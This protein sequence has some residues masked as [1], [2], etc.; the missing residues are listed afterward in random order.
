MSSRRAKSPDAPSIGERIDA[1]QS[2]AAKVRAH[3]LFAIR[4]YTFTFQVQITTAGT[5]F[6]FPSATEEQQRYLASLLRPFMSQ[7]DL[8]SLGL[9]FRLF[10]TVIND[11]V[12]RQGLADIRDDYLQGLKSTLFASTTTWRAGEQPPTRMYND[13]EIAEAYLYGGG[14]IH[15]NAEPRRLYQQLQGPGSDEWGHQAVMRHFHLAGTTA[16][17][18]DDL[19]RLAEE[20]KVLRVTPSTAC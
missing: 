13:R 7:R 3:P 14:L 2:L 20:Q 8:P 1:F 9:C 11:A 19:L 10:G 12:L 6:S 17:L 18:V 15:M 5:R 16:L 4:D